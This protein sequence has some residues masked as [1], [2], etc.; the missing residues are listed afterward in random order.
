VSPAAANAPPPLPADR[1]AR[2]ERAWDER[3]LANREQVE[4]I[5]Q[6]EEADDFYAP[7]TA[8]F[9]E[10]PRRTGDA[11]LDALLELA[12]AGER[13]LDVGAGAGRYALPLALRVAEVVAVEPSAA[14]VA[15]LRAGMAEHG[16]RNLRVIEDRWPPS[17]DPP[18]ADVALIA[19]VGYDVAPIA[20]F[21]DALEG[22]AGRCVAVMMDTSPAAYAAPF[23]PIIHGEERVPLPALPELVD[24]LRA[25]GADPQVRHLPRPVRHWP[26]RASLLTMLRQQLWI[27][28]G[29]A[30]E[31]ELIAAAEESA[32]AVADGV[33][34]PE[35]DGVIGI[36][37][38]R[39]TYDRSD[40]GRAEAEA[41]R[42]PAQR[43]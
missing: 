29:G 16:I 42:W 6:G 1:R 11:V 41:A 40:V 30:A 38:W 21:L 33:G 5:R 14:M 22:A 34:L 27:P 19:H 25:R 23:W 28:N 18:S 9:V 31:A 12:V 20:L 4:R 15:A 13:W 3:V 35:P 10:D 2:L 7:V 24:L 32:I 43:S 39:S 17:A 36:V 8:R 37:A 26:D